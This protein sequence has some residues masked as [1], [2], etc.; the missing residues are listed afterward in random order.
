MTD[1]SQHVPKHL[2]RAHEHMAA[3]LAR[4]QAVH[5]QIAARI[6]ARAQEAAQAAPDPPMEATP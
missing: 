3:S 4:R 5:A 1:D 6:L 2:R